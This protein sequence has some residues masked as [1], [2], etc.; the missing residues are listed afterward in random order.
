MAPPRRVLQP[1]KECLFCGSKTDLTD[2]HLIPF[3]L[4]GRIV[5]PNGS[6]RSCAKVT[7]LL[8]QRVARNHLQIPRSIGGVQTR[9]PSQR[10]NETKI[11]LT[12]AD[13]RIAKKMFSLDIAPISTIVL[14]FKPD[15]ADFWEE[16]LLSS[17]TAQT[18]GHWQNEERTSEIFKKTGAKTMTWRTG[19]IEINSWVRV[20]WKMACCFFFVVC[21]RSFI[22]SDRRKTVLGHRVAPP[23]TTIEEGRNEND[24]SSLLVPDIFSRQHTDHL[25]KFASARVYTTER[26]EHS[27]VYCEMNVLSFLG[28]PKYTCRILNKEGVS[29]GETKFEVE[30]E[31][32]LLGGNRSTLFE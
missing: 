22:A 29:L 24:D 6:C 3:S 30:E 10:P 23:T 31:C 2:E 15:K 8:E 17:C 12:F 14:N 11:K 27:H 28:F 5:L 20:L 16:E 18:V 7:A 4:G 13:G 32:F 9:R 25:K 19:G 26:D 1:S 21:P